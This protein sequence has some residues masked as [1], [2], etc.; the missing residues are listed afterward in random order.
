MPFL[1]FPLLRSILFSALLFS[2]LLSTQAH[3]IK[4]YLPETLPTQI[5]KAVSFELFLSE[6]Q[7]ANDLDGRATG[8]LNAELQIEVAPGFNLYKDKLS[9][10]APSPWESSI[11]N[12]PKEI[13]F[14]D[15]ITTKLKAGYKGQVLF[16]L[17]VATP[18]SGIDSS[19]PLTSLKINVTFQACNKELCLLPAIVELSLP[20]VKDRAAFEASI[21]NNPSNQVINSDESWIERQTAFLQNQ[22]DSDGLSWKLLLLLLLAGVLTAFTPCVYPLYPI[23]IGIFSK[24][25]SE[26]APKTLLLSLLYCLGLTASYAAVGL[27]TASSGLLFG[28]LTQTPAFLLSVGFLILFSA[29]AFSGLLPFQAPQFLQRIF[30]GSSDMTEQS[31]GK[32][33]FQSL[34]MGC[35]LGVVAAPCVG[36]VIIALMA[37]LSGSL[38]QSSEAYTQGALALS[39]FGFGMSLPF[40][41][42]ANILVG[43]K[44]QPQLGRFTPW[45]KHAGT[46]LM[47]AGSMFFLVPGAQLLLNKPSE[48]RLDFKIW[49]LSE[50]PLDK[51]S[52]IDFRADWCAACHELEAETFSA[53]Q[54]SEKFKSEKWNF[55]Q[56]DLTTIDDEKQKIIDTYSI[57]GLPTVLI[58]DPSGKICDGLKLFGFENA[59][60]FKSRM[61]KAV[62]DGCP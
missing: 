20:F 23:T 15:P 18:E 39:F 43:L 16:K 51:W 47:I 42:L 48:H 45:F 46:V 14:L 37:W 38:A 13:R 19:D 58:R 49:S 35:G 5:K 22:L 57:V 40:L 54:I 30:S 61:D 6:N 8:H 52:V 4:T 56:Q 11:Y 17:K 1:S 60:L 26:S 32:R 2:T 25:S 62:K 41:I 59:E 21:N 31:F 10:K 24:W 12:K 9:I 50:A 29:L 36:P 28:S 3:A 34:F 27:I 7:I 33:S 55:I 44:N 53:A